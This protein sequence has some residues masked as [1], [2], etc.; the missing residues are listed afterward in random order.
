VPEGITG[1]NLRI[2]SADRFDPACTLPVA[3]NVVPPFYCYPDRLLFEARDGEQLR[4]IFI[5]QRGGSAVGLREIRLPE[6]G[7]RYEVF[8]GSTPFN[9]RVNVYATGMAEHVGEVGDV[10]LLTD[11]EDE[12]HRE[13]A[14]PIVVS[15]E[16]LE[17]LI[18]GGPCYGVP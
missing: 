16:P 2:T 12:R 18:R 3:A 13:I 4:M 17:P 8:H 5:D 1:A 7:F 6:S 15:L 10:V 11:S 9:Y 14:I